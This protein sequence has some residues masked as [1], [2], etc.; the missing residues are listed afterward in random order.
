MRRLSESG[1][2]VLCMYLAGDRMVSHLSSLYAPSYPNKVSAGLLSDD[3][4][5]C[6]FTPDR[7]LRTNN[8]Q[9][10]YIL[11]STP[12]ISPMFLLLQ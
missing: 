3:L 8:Y 10:T 2:I 11:H 7:L 5:Y 4:K 9:R 12:S 6:P 1:K